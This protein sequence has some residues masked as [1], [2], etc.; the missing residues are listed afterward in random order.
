MQLP[1]MGCLAGEVPISAEV[2]LCD[3]NTFTNCVTV[4]DWQLPGVIDGDEHDWTCLQLL[5]TPEPCPMWVERWTGTEWDVCDPALANCV[6]WWLHPQRE[7]TFRCGWG[8]NYYAASQCIALQTF[9]NGVDE[10]VITTN[11][12]Q[13]QPDPNTEGDP[14]QIGGPAPLPS[15]RPTRSWL[16]RIVD[17]W[18][19]GA[20]PDL[21]D[22]CWPSGWGLLNPLQ[23]VMRPTMCALTYLFVPGTSLQTRAEEL[24]ELAETK[25]GLGTAQ[26]AG[27]LLEGLGSPSVGGAC[28]WGISAIDAGPLQTPAVDLILCPSEHGLSG[29][30]STIRGWGNAVVGVWAAGMVYRWISLSRSE[31]LGDEILPAGNI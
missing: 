25:V 9:Y 16:G 6:D 21:M 15:S 17:E 14:V 24:Y 28:G 2:Q 13:P 31:E 27:E 29:T 18:A 19:A 20:T 22:S 8:G 26:E 7:T 10:D 23:W 12:T 4:A 30:A 1:D 3:S 11:P 5:A